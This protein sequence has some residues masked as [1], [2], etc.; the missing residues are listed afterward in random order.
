MM[1]D[2]KAVKPGS[3]IEVRLRGHEDIADGVYPAQVDFVFDDH[4]M[5][6]VEPGGDEGFAVAV[7]EADDSGVWLWSKRPTG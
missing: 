6:W 7:M 4:L 2:L 1:R 5:V 3:K